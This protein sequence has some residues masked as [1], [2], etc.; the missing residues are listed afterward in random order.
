MRIKKVDANQKQIVQ[1]LRKYPGISVSHTH[2]IGDGFPD[3]VVGFRGSNFL[4]EIKDGSKP[5]SARKLTP[6]EEIWHNKWAGQ[7]EIVK[8]IDEILNLMDYPF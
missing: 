6:D 2:I 1:G 3:I 4:F 5:P 8:N 7:I